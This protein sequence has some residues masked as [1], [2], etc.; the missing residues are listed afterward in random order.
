MTTCFHAALIIAF[1]AD[2]VLCVAVEIENTTALNKRLGQLSTINLISLALRGH[3]NL[4]VN[5]C[6]IKVENY[7]CIH[8]WLG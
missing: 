4:I 5:C 2:N 8:Q 1:V 7:Q 3:M 6:G